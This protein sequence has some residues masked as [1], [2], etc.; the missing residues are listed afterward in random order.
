VRHSQVLEHI[1]ALLISNIHDHCEVLT[2]LCRMYKDLPIM[3]NDTHT[4]RRRRRM[5]EVL[6]GLLYAS[7]HQQAQQ[8]ESIQK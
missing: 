7:P 5:I 3:V 2:R 8:L 4:R 6:V 1:V